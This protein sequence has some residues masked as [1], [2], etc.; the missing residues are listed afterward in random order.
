MRMNAT[1]DALGSALTAAAAF[2]FGWPVFGVLSSLVA[3]VN[4]LVK[5]NEMY[6]AYSLGVRVAAAIPDLEANPPME[7]AMGRKLLVLLNPNAGAGRGGLI[8]TRCVDP[9]FRAAGIDFDTITTERSG[10]ASDICLELARSRMHLN[11]VRYDAVVCV[12]GDGML[13]EAIQGFARSCGGHADLLKE[14]LAAVALAIVPAGSGN[15]VAASLRMGDPLKAALAIVR[16]KPSPVDLMAARRLGKDGGAFGAGGGGGGKPL[17]PKVLKVL[18]AEVQH[19]AEP[20]VWDVHFFSWCAFADH[21]YLTEKPLRNL[22]PLLKM[23]LAPLIIIA[24]GRHY[25]GTVDFLPVEDDDAARWG[26]EGG[27]VERRRKR[28]D[29]PRGADFDA[30]PERD[31]TRGAVAASGRGSAAAGGEGRWRRFTAKMWCFACGNLDHG[32]L[33]LQPVPFA[34]RNEGAFDLLL[35]RRRPY[36]ARWLFLKLFIDMEKGDHLKSEYVECLKVKAAV[37]RPA[38]SQPFGIGHMQCSGEEVPGGAGDFLIQSFQGMLRMIVDESNWD[39]DD[40]EQ[41]GARGG[42]SKKDK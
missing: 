38:H 18:G 35:T 2:Y 39:G 29:D 28:Y 1:L 10:H 12:S 9:V 26:A 11:A 25:Q 31:P 15:G 37:V 8:F 36:F 20:P 13:H 24:R 30:S 16:G 5:A 3:V 14:V 23:I 27:A 41:G 33:D 22:G 40:K 17:P 32:A 19:P 42:E 6:S 7:W 21:D 34:R 4:L